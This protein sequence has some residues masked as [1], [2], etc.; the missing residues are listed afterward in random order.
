MKSFLAAMRQIQRIN[1][2]T[3][4]VATVNLVNASTQRSDA[5]DT[6]R[7]VVVF[8]T[9]VAQRGVGGEDIPFECIS[10]KQ[11]CQNEQ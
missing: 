3:T 4:V 1:K 9:V 8:V 2:T 5:G 11:R 7:R 10:Y 6:R